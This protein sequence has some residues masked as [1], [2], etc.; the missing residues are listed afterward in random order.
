MRH[1]TLVGLLFFFFFYIVAFRLYCVPKFVR[2]FLFV[3]RWVRFFFN[4]FFLLYATLGC[5]IMY[6]DTFDEPT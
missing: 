4:F 2:A 6:T 1:R 3:Y 5:I